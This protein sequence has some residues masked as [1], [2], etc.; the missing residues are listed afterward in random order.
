M[1]GRVSLSVIC[2]DLERVIADY[3]LVIDKTPLRCF[4]RTLKEAA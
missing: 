1:E 2:A 4:T 3:E